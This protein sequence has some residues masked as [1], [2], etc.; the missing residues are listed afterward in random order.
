MW[1]KGQRQ[2]QRRTSRQ[3]TEQALSNQEVAAAGWE[4]NSLP[5]FVLWGR[6]SKSPSLVALGV[7][8]C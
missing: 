1:G 2:L 6:E 8:G 7:N 5:N 4:Q 3:R